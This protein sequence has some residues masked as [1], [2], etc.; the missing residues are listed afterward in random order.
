LTILDQNAIADL[1][2]PADAFEFPPLATE[3][4]TADN[5]VS[6]RQFGRPGSS[7]GQARPRQRVD[8]RRRVALHDARP[9]A[10]VLVPTWRLFLAS[11]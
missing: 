7:R 1:G 5:S 9:C 6:H 11:C 3:V 4:F 2:E 10:R 8:G